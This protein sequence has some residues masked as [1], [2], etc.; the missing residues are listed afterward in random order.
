[1]RV[2]NKRLYQKSHLYIIKVLKSKITKEVI[3]GTKD[4]FIITYQMAM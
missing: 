4:K 2:E 1:M 3:Y